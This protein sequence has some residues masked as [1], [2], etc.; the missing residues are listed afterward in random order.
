MS[1]KPPSACPI[2]GNCPECLARTNALLH[3]PRT[4]LLPGRPTVA[5]LERHARKFGPAQVAE[6]A[7]EHGLSVAVERDAPRRRTTG[8][9][10]RQRVAGYV[11]ADYSAEVIAEL[12]GLSP[13]RA[14]R[15]VAE[16]R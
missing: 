10:L 14:R 3:V 5:A 11:D 2:C 6:T 12:E 1:T 9:T 8:P 16:I 15:L 13:S 4:S 7:A